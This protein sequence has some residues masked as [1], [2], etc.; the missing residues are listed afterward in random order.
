M[1]IKHLIFT[2]IL[3]TLS[4]TFPIQSLHWGVRWRYEVDTEL[5]LTL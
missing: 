2:Q 3:R 5:G 4:L 1:S